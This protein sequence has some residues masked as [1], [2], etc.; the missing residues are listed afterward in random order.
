MIPR[1][2][3]ARVVGTRRVRFE[4]SCIPSIRHGTGVCLL[5]W[6]TLAPRAAAR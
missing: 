4:Q 2:S 6:S 1:L 3:Q 5:R